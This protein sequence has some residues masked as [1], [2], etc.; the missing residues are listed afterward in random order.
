MKIS[1]KGT[2]MV[3]PGFI[4]QSL[5]RDD[6]TITFPR[7]GFTVSRKIGNAAERNRVKRR[8]RHAAA[9]VFRKH[10]KSDCDYVLIGRKSA[11]TIPFQN[12]I[13]DMEKLIR[14]I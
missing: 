8:L 6:E 5:K 9:G 14:L 10:A 11:L 1:K 12:L 2:S 13:K 3:A 7:L 4:M